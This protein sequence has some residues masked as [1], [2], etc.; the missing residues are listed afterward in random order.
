MNRVGL[1]MKKVG[2]TTL[3]TADSVVIPVTL[4][5]LEDNIVLSAKKHEGTTIVK[6]SF[7]SL[8]NVNKPQ[9]KYFEKLGVEK[10][11]R[12]AEFK[13]R[14]DVD[15]KPLSSLS[16]EHFKGGQFVDVVGTSIG[17]G[18]SLIHI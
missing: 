8:K 1:L 2:C 3:Y 16:V 12:V 5:T 15:I 10:I 13:L 18:L 9:K 11:G 17:K 14:G 6:V 4:L 7:G